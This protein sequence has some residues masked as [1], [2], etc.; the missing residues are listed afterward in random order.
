MP[1]IL[2]AS[3]IAHWVILFWCCVGFFYCH[4]HFRFTFFKILVSTEKQFWLVCILSFFCSPVDPFLFILQ[5]FVGCCRF[6][7]ASWSL[8][9]HSKVSI[10]YPSCCFSV[11]SFFYTLGNQNKNIVRDLSL[12]PVCFVLFPVDSHLCQIS[13]L[14]LGQ[15]CCRMVQ[16]TSG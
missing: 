11:V 14:H 10:I 2:D 3:Q 8:M 1:T 6:Q 5:H 4:L 7:L 15:V 9:K 13:R 12:N 16:A